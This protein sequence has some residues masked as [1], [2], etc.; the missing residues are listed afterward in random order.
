VRASRASGF[1]G[2]IEEVIVYRV[3]LE[4]GGALLRRVEAIATRRS[5]VI[6]GRNALKGFVVRLDGPRDE[7]ELRLVKSRHR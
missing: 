6:I 3:D 7:L 1:S 4:F 2:S 5:Y